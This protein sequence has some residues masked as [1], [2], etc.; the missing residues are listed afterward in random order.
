MIPIKRGLDL[1]VNGSPVQEVDT[2]SGV[3]RVAVV[4]DDYVGMKP[5]LEVSVGDAVR[6]GSRLF[7]DRKSPGVVYTSPAG[8]T[9]V[10]IN[11]GPKRVFQSL[12]IETSADGAE[13]AEEF[14]SVGESG[15]EGLSPERLR[16]TLV[17][18][19]M[20]TAFRQR[21][22]SIVPPVD[23]SPDAVFVTAIDT[24]PLA[25]DPAVVLEA[26]A[27]EFVLGLRVL[28]QL[29]EMP[30]YLVTAPDA[31]IPG[32]GVAGVIHKTFA[33]PHPA[34]LPGTHMHFLG[35]V[36]ESRVGWHVGYQ[37]VV[38]IGKLLTTGRLDC[39]RV[40]SLCGPGAIR[41]RLIRTRLG[42]SLEELAE[43]EIA[44]GSVRVISG[45]VLSGRTAVGAEGYLGRYHSQISFL[46][47]PTEREFLGWQ[48]PGGDKFSVTRAFVG[49]ARFAIQSVLGIRPAVEGFRF[50]T[51]L[52][53]SDRAMVPVG[54]YERVMPLDMIPTYLLRALIVGDT[55]QAK[56][57]GALELDEEDLALCTYVCPGKYDFGTLLRQNLEQIRREG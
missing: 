4:G 44:A 43:G 16:E 51:S 15:I 57:L 19:G 55:E 29:G 32:T 37:D 17:G 28:R 46:P 23:S 14:E 50:D 20:W 54:N 56:A 30:L 31:E 35:P 7:S 1:P 18:S 39:Q 2:S 52:N 53:G 27:A 22:F 45:S 40:V 25:A 47:E 6:L 34:G 41:P 21:P 33:G 48:R 36:G 49:S 10:E 38:A 13:G 42:A 11:R 9:V 12:V 26:Q 5:A 8:G 3:R 24:N